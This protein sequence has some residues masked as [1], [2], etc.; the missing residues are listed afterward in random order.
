MP[1]PGQFARN[2]RLLLQSSARHTVEDPA[3]F[4][5]QVSRCLIRDNAEGLEAV[6]VGTVKLTGNNRRRLVDGVT[7]LLASEEVCV[8]MADAV[9]TYG[10]SEVAR[11]SMEAILWGIRGGLRLGNFEPA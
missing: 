10:D 2:A 1:S 6:G 11:C 3:P 5:A 7:L 8:G 9:N 4:V